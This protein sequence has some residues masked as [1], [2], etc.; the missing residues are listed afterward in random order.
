MRTTL[1]I[2]DDVLEDVKKQARIQ[3]R[4][5][6]EVLSELARAQMTARG[7]RNYTIVNGFAVFEPTG[8]SVTNELIDRIREEEGI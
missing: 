1:N 3:Q 4:T 8:Q 2:D 6:G 5:A 7:E